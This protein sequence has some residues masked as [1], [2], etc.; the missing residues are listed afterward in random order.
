MKKLFVALAMAG[1]ALSGARC[2][3]AVAAEKITAQTL[4]DRAQI[5]DLITRHYNISAAKTPRTSPTSTRR[6]PRPASVAFVRGRTASCGAMA[7]HRAGRRANARALSFIVTI[8]NP[9]IVVHG[10][11]ATARLVFTEFVI[12][13]Q[14]EGARGLEGIA[15]AA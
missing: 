9:L 6:T 4:I 7:A 14:G 1:F 13:K 11:T 3:A 8:G 10:G 12:E 15:T 5:T 2:R